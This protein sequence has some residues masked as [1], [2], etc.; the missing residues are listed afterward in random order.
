MREF[1]HSMRH[2]SKLEDILDGCGFPGRRF[3]NQATFISAMLMPQEEPLAGCIVKQ[4]APPPELDVPMFL[5]AT[6]VRIVTYVSNTDVDDQSAAQPLTHPYNLIDEISYYE[7]G[8]EDGE[9]RLKYK[10]NVKVVIYNRVE[11][12]ILDFVSNISDLNTDIEIKRAS[13]PMGPG[14][15]KRERIRHKTLRIQ[16]MLGKVV[17]SRTLTMVLNILLAAAVIAQA[18]VLLTR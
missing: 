11:S 2:T 18:A 7:G 10:G 1:M 16:K 6:N 5:I 17:A 13:T 15:S 3:A 9:F 12:T 4:Y 8:R 14:F